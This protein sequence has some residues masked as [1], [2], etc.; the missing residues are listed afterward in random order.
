MHEVRLR[1][2]Y[3]I[4]RGGGVVPRKAHN[5]ETR[6]QIPAPQQAQQRRALWRVF[7]VLVA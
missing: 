6:V 4:A 2:L 5:L 3:Y 7:V 1:F